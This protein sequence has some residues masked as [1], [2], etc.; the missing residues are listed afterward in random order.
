MLLVPEFKGYSYLSVSLNCSLNSILLITSALFNIDS[1]FENTY[2]EIWLS[3]K[4]PKINSYSS[5]LIYNLLI[6]CNDIPI[7]HVSIFNILALRSLIDV[8]SVAL[9]ADIEFAYHAAVAN[10]FVLLL[11]SFLLKSS[12]V[13]LWVI[14]SLTFLVFLSVSNMTKIRLSTA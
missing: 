13:S 5:L 6:D 7:I 8:L 1:P 9:S 14:I 2:I 12:L 10:P 11:P 3:K 4:R